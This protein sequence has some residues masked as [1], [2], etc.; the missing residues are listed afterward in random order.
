VT[1][2]QEA[3]EWMHKIH[4][5][6]DS[7]KPFLAFEYNSFLTS[8]GSTN[9]NAFFIENSYAQIPSSFSWGFRA[10]SWYCPFSSND[11]WQNASYWAGQYDGWAP[12]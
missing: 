10:I 9:A 3:F 11:A 12:R 6:V 1:V 7:T 5:Y 8:N 4:D 2:I